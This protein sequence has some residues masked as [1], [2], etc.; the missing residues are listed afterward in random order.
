MKRRAT[1]ILLGIMVSSMFLSACGKNEAKEAANES[2]QDLLYCFRMTIKF[3]HGGNIRICFCK[4]LRLQHLFP[5][6]KYCIEQIR[7][8]SVVSPEVLQRREAGLVLCGGCQRSWGI[9]TAGIFYHNTEAY[10]ARAAFGCDPDFRA[11]HG[12]VLYCRYPGRK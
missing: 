5:V 7:K 8:M 9:Q 10:T 6:K 2:A 11:I 4:I 12:T 1:A 3:Q